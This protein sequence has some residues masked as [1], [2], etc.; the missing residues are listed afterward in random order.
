[1]ETIKNNVY[2]TMGERLKEL[3]K[4]RGISAKE[5]SKRIGVSY[6]AYIN[7]ENDKRIPSGDVVLAM[8]TALAVSTDYLLAGIADSKDLQKLDTHKHDIEPLINQIKFMLL[9]DA[10]VTYRKKKLSA[11][12]REVLYHD[13]GTVEFHAILKSD[14][15]AP[16]FLDGFI[17]GFGKYGS[18]SG[19]TFDS[20]GTKEDASAKVE[21]EQEDFEK[22]MK[23]T[24]LDYAMA[25]LYNQLKEKYGVAFVDEMKKE[26]KKAPNPLDSKQSAPPDSDKD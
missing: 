14:E 10:D 8:A 2:S 23:E 3:R 15:T 24:Y 26:I 11:E 25:Q 16:K 21:N 7:Y 18:S 1:M 4:E 9:T 19:I 5:L 6:P 17:G 22:K 13:V 20:T 12:T